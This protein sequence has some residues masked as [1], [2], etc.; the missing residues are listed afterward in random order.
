MTESQMNEL[1][2]NSRHL[3]NMDIT[4]NFTDEKNHVTRTA[5][6]T[7]LNETS[8]LNI[9]ENGGT[10]SYSINVWV[11]EKG[12]DKKHA[13]PLYNVLKAYPAPPPAN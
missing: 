3:L 10:K 5:I 9:G 2:Q 8:S 12:T 6:C 7:V 11:Q 4:V 13:I 1:I